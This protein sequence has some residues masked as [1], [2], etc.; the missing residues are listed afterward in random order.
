MQIEKV[1]DR[2]E[3]YNFTDSYIIII[4]M[5][6]YNYE[7]EWKKR[8]REA[9]SQQKSI[10]GENWKRSSEPIG[11]KSTQSGVMSQKRRKTQK[12]NMS[13]IYEIRR[14]RLFP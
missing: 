11:N 10:D 6:T 14:K 13:E 9:I 7:S 2:S 4:E 3:N 5:F 12:N 8:K 1:P